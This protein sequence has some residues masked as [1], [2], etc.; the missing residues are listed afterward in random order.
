MTRYTRLLRDGVPCWVALDDDDGATWLSAAPYAGGVSDAPVGPLPATR[1]PC[2]APSKIICVGRNYRAHAAELGND[3]PTEP[4]LFMKPP[5][6]LIGHGEAIVLP[7][8]SE[9]VEHEGELGVVIGT[10]VHRPDP[11][12]AEESIFGFTIVNDVTARDLQRRDKKFTRGKGFDTFCPVGPAI[13]P[14]AE[15]P[16]AQDLE[17]TLEVSGVRKQHGR[18]SQM[19]FG[20]V[21]LIVFIAGIMT[22][23][24]GDLICT[25]TPAGVGPLVDGDSVIITI[26]GIGTLRNPVSSTPT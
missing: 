17:I 26:E 9:R 6:A 1:L 5:S 4:M 10:R 12:A 16:N 20:V 15:V 21:E 23:E 11:R 13:V 25:G 24:P 7:E 18:T 14:R 8:Q 19:V 22:L 2:V 3:V